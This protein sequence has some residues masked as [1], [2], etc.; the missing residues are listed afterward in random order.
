MENTSQEFYS[1]REAAVKLGLSL[2]TVQKM[3]EIG[4]L[5]A[6][7]TSGGHRRVLASSLED[8]IRSRQSSP[9]VVRIRP[10]LF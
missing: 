8:Y 1:T 3:V 9:Q 7:K 5:S 10:Y 6:W 2:G 4:A